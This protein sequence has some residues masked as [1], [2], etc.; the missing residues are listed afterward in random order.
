VGACVASEPCQPLTPV[1]NGNN[2][3]CTGDTSPAD[4]S[5]VRCGDGMASCPANQRCFEQEDDEDLFSGEDQASIT[6]R[7]NLDNQIDT[8]RSALQ[9]A[10]GEDSETSVGEDGYKCS[11]NIECESYY[12]HE[13][14]CAAG[15]A[16]ICRKARL[17]EEAAGSVECEDS[18]VKNSQNICSDVNGIPSIP[19][20]LTDFFTGTANPTPANKCEIGVV[21]AQESLSVG[22]LTLRAFEWLYET[23]NSPNE[24]LKHQET[25]KPVINKFLTTPRKELLVKFNSGWDM[26]MRDFEKLAGV[27]EGV[28]A[29]NLSAGNNS[30]N[31][32]N[33]ET[34]VQNSSFGTNQPTQSPGLQNPTFT[35]QEIA[36]Y[37]ASGVLLYRLLWNRAHLLYNY[38]N[39]MKAMTDTF[40]TKMNELNNYYTGLNVDS[41]TWTFG[42]FV[43]S[44]YQSKSYGEKDVFCRYKKKMKVEKRWRRRYKFAK[45]DVNRNPNIITEDVK[46]FSKLVDYSEDKNY[47]SHLLEKKRLFLIDPMMPGGNV[48]GKSHDFENH[49]SGEKYGTGGD[50]RRGL[51]TLMNNVANN[52]N[53]AQKVTAAINPAVG[54]LLFIL[55]KKNARSD[56]DLMKGVMVGSMPYYLKSSIGPNASEA[57][58]FAE[59]ELGISTKCLNELMLN[60]VH[61]PIKNAS[62]DCEYAERQMLRLGDIGFAQFLLYSMHTKRK[63]K[64]GYFQTSDTNTLKGKMA[65]NKFVMEVLDKLSKYYEVMANAHKAQMDCYEKLS[66]KGQAILAEDQGV[67]IGFSEYGVTPQE[68]SGSSQQAGT[69]T[70][71]AGGGNKSVNMN[72]F[73]FGSKAFLTKFSGLSNSDK[74]AKD[75]I[76]SRANLA[77]TQLAAA[78]IKK[79]NQ[80]KRKAF[81]AKNPDKA[82]AANELVASLTKSLGS[83]VLNSGSGGIGSGSGSGSNS[84]SG[85]SSSSLGDKSSQT[86]S[87]SGANAKKDGSQDATSRF[88]NGVGGGAGSFDSGYSSFKSPTGSGDLSSFSDTGMTGLSKEQERNMLNE[89]DKAKN[90]LSPMDG[91]SLFEVVSKG[92]QRNLNKVLKKKVDKGIDPKKSKASDTDKKAIQDSL[93]GL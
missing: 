59:P 63:F 1:L 36:G 15:I 56:I 47:F 7:E 80:D 41:K 12:C 52:F 19:T 16:K 60:F 83:S 77:S 79:K 38:E 86:A 23:M 26:V 37:N 74:V 11:K 39:D 17:G 22:I 66:Q 4:S 89:I 24:C 43:N 9:L 87:L 42:E 50:K 53:T 70:V 69:G 58:S 27:S 5:L 10:W 67:Q 71:R 82:K 21:T 8:V 31:S 48:P 18:L 2:Y 25:F 78:A 35:S 49:Y 40:Y 54:A 57:H 90:E 33:F 64:D 85:S 6:A 51:G 46:N 32:I 93:K 84:S 68:N 65:M 20:E 61:D 30:V 73:A 92:Y 14:K 81:A 44:N 76:F 75:S 3:T 88:G 91:D 45:S 62:K 13:G 55:D 28:D 34:L 72:A 29:L